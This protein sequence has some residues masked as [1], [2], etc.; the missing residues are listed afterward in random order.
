[1][2]KMENLQL[3]SL[4]TKTNNTKVI[5]LQTLHIC[6]YDAIGDISER[7]VLRPQI[8]AYTFNVLFSLVQYAL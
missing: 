4:Y 1:M 8:F 6:V 2:I 7:L 5:R 3:L